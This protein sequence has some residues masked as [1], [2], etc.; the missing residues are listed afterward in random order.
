[1]SEEKQDKD[2]LKLEKERWKGFFNVFYSLPPESGLTPRQAIWKKNKATLW[3]YPTKQKKYKIPL[4]LIYSMV[5]QP[6][7]LDLAPG[8]STIESLL[9]EGYDVYLID[10]GIPGYEDKDLTIN[11]YI[12]EY[13]QKGVQRALKHSK[14]KEVTLIGY[15]LGGTLTAM[16]T[17][18]AEEPIKN[19]I[20]TVAPIDFSTFPIFDK[21]LKAANNGQL[22]FDSLLETIGLVPAFFIKAGVR[23]ITSPIYFSPYLSLLNRAYD[24]EYVD[25]W[26]RLNNWTNGHIPFPGAAL[27]QFMDDMG[28]GNKLIDGGIEINGKNAVLHN[29]HANLLVV[30]SKYD[31]LVPEPLIYPVMDHV[32][33]EDKTYI[34]L[35]DGHTGLS[36]KG[37]IPDYM[38]N[39]LHERSEAI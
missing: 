20:L 30:A 6:F 8:S 13:I 14:A 22:N 27:K 26:Q 4:I 34:S 9:N 28:K 19:L 17:A 32:S 37:G 36:L 5:N 7:I 16:Y 39:W 10:F 21:W 11:Y 15:C 38:K 23:M 35:E 29:I 24:K 31:R 18:I 2:Y 12:T 25:Q 33:S 3:Y 1:M